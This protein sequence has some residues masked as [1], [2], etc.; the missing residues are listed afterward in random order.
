VLNHFLPYGLLTLHQLVDE[1]VNQVVT[2]PILDGAI[3]LASLLELLV[4]R[5]LEFPTSPQTCGAKGGT[6]AGREAHHG[7]TSYNL[8][9]VHA[10]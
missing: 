3:V 5:I 1:V 8:G 4:R 10:L 7:Q 9:A 2:L 6:T